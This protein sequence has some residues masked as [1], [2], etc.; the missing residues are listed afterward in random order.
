MLDSFGFETVNPAKEDIVERV[1]AF[2]G[3]GMAD[4]VFEVSGSPEAVEVMT[5]LVSVRGRIIMVAVHKV[6]RKVNLHR[7]YWSEVELIGARL[8]ES[9]DFEEAIRIAS[10]G[11]IPFEELITQVK[12]LDEI[13]ALFEEIDRHPSGMKSLVDCRV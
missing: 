6:P 12:P 8:Y 10:T 7:F 9:E 3:E 4:A 2:T 1:S 13:Q 5:D 11:R